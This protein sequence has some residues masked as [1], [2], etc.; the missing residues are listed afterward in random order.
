M[1]VPFLIYGLYS[2]NRFPMRG[3]LRMTGLMPYVT[4]LVGT[5][6]VVYMLFNPLKMENYQEKHTGRNVAIY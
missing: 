6:A 4:G 3:R 1:A 5:V 2:H